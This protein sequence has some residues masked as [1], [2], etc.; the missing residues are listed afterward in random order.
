MI[1]GVDIVLKHSIIVTMSYRV[2][3]KV[4]KH[5]YVYEVESYWD[6]NKK[7]P[8]QNRT[9]LGKKN[10]ITG[11][12]IST[13]KGYISLDYGNTYFLYEVA[14][15]LD[16]H[17]LLSQIF[18]DIWQE[19]L[20]CV[21]FEISEKKAL[22]LCKPWMECSYNIAERDLS[23]QR[24]SEL[25]H[26][27][28]Q[29]EEERIKFLKAWAWQHSANEYI[30]FDITS[31]SSYAKKLDFLEWGYNRDREKLPQINFGVIYGEPSA[32][33]LFYTRYP[34][35]IKDVTTLD[36]MVE[37]LEWLELSD[38]LFVLDR[39]FFS[40]YNLKKMNANMRFVIPLPYSN[41][42]AAT[43]IKKHRNDLA[44]HSNAFQLNKQIM[45]GVTN[46]I[47][48]GSKRYYCHLYLD[49]KRR[50]EERERFLSKVLEL[51]KKVEEPEL[52]ENMEEL[53]G[54][55]SDTVRGWEKIFEIIERDGKFW[56]KR[57]EKGINAQLEKMGT[58]I[59]LSNK[60]FDGKEVL[61]LYRR[62]DVIEKF[63]DNMKHDIERKR[64]RIHSQE[65]FEGRLFLDFLALIIYSRISSVMREEGINKDLTVQELMYELKKIKLI[66]LG[67][68]KMIVTEVSK[69]QRELFQ[70][71]K[72][73]LPTR[74]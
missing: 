52:R 56:I 39:G 18:P 54:F 48:I 25:L 2:D 53:Q 19:L 43:L 33:P 68:K 23:S 64:L 31:F 61:R 16:L 14:K 21:F 45:Y 4:G 70:S 34:G 24:I 58:M 13:R 9:F 22:Y 49:E 66:R 28:G 30:V 71:F 55:L 59:L 44:L 57:K 38:T 10:P 3:Q 6:K 42:N 12:L 35:S 74:P 26:D 51:E 73:P 29:Q 36:N 37:Y 60:R 32:L 27:L 7:Q 17:V 69:K 15:Q 50:V 11:E 63:F 8:R 65:T 62:K 40:S 5:T 72:I 47:E 41:N 20:T 67:T 1:F 46:R